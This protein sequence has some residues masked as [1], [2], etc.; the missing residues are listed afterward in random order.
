MLGNAYEYD[1]TKN[2]FNTPCDLCNEALPNCCVVC[3]SDLGIQRCECIAECSAYSC[4]NCV[5]R[6]CK[7]FYSRKMFYFRECCNGNFTNRCSVECCDIA[8]CEM[9]D[10]EYIAR[11]TK[12]VD[13]SCD[14]LM[15]RCE[16]CGEY[17]CSK[18]PRLRCCDNIYFDYKY[19][20]EC[21]GDKLVKCKTCDSKFCTQC[22]DNYNDHWN[23]C[24]DVVSESDDDV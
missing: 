21:E 12:K 13:G 4:G 19:C 20:Y 22:S 18:H 3:I 1:K 6:K 23:E 5:C 15:G 17:F 8:I 16:G 2:R 9:C 11:E 7:S 24:G 10:E 14:Q